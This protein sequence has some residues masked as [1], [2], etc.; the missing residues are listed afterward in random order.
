MKKRLS[1]PREKIEILLFEGIHQSAV[2]FFQQHD[3]T[4]V[5]RHSRAMHGDELHQAIARAHIVGVRSRTQLTEDVLE[6]AERLLAIG[7]FCIGINQV[8]L[9]NAAARGIPVF[10]APHS[11]TRSVA[12]MVIAE[13][14]MLLRGLGDKN[15]AAHQ[16]AWT[17]SA[18][19]SYELRGKTV[20]IVGYGHIGYQ[21][22]ILAEAMGMRVL[23]HD[24]LQ[25]LPMGN[26]HQMVSLDELLPQVDFLTLHVP[27][28]ESTKDMI[29][30][31]ELAKMRPGSYLLNASRG[32][33]VVV[34]AL[35]DAIRSQHL[36]GAAIDV[37]PKEPASND[38]PFESSLR[39]LPNVIL[40]PHIGGSTVEAQR[41]IGT[42]VASKLVRYSDQGATTGA[43]NFPELSLAPQENAHRLL[44]IHHN[45][46]GVL[47]NV[48]R[49]LAASDGN[50]VG[51]HLQTTAEVGYV[52]TDIKGH[53]A[54]GLK[55]TLQE[56]PGTIRVRALY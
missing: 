5:T 29:G 45:R 18:K 19:H 8:N 38:E 52:V 42:E 14:I 1:Y 17:K 9:P 4:N 11:N 7:C 46:P 31:A 3:Y 37:Y 53:D 33:V 34:D 35:A 26:A 49:V 32:T 25:K 48:N 51:Q 56:I 50:I 47:A 13:M 28:D 21:V 41:N 22:S 20:G 2:D 40:T 15:T 44:H 54:A 30:A 55:K 16:G 43:V 27:Q 23:Y 12:E 6:R 10:N 39:G 24:I 36:R